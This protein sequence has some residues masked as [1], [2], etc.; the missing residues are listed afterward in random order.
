MD[1]DVVV[2]EF[3]GM[4]AVVVFLGWGVRGLRPWRGG[5]WAGGR[6]VFGEGGLP[7]SW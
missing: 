4:M 3:L 2:M 5:C 1:G 6:G 7:A